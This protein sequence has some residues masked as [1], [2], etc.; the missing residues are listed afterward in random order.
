MALDAKVELFRRYDET[1]NLIETH[2]HA[3]DFKG[4]VFS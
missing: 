2:E 1:S 3:G 4:P